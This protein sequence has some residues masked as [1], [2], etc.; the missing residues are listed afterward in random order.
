MQSK[1]KWNVNVYII[2]SEA[3]GGKNLLNWGTTLKSLRK[4]C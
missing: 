4:F 1:F 3:F 2:L